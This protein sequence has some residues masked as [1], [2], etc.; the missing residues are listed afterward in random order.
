MQVNE[1]RRSTQIKW[2]EKEGG[3]KNSKEEVA[4][5]KCS[6]NK[7]EEHVRRRSRNKNPEVVGKLQ[8]KKKEGS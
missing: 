3:K 1:F 7:Q 8:L 2:A 6:S 5:R 4:R